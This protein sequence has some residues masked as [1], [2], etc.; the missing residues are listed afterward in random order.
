MKKKENES[1]LMLKLVSLLLALLIWFRISGTVKEKEQIQ[2]QTFTNILLEYQEVPKSIEPK[3]SITSFVVNVSGTEKDLKELERTGFHVDLSLG[4]LRQGNYTFPLTSEN[5]KFPLELTSLKFERIIPDTAVVNLIK[6]IRKE[7]AL[8]VYTEGEPAEDY[9]LKE[10]VLN[11]R[12]VEIEGPAREIEELRFLFGEN[13]NI[14]GL[15]ANKSGLITLETDQ[16]PEDTVIYGITNLR[17]TV[18]IE[19]NSQ[20]LNPKETYPVALEN[21]NWQINS[22]PEVKLEIEGPVTIIRW[23]DPTW[24]Q[25]TLSIPRPKPAPIDEGN[26]L[27]SGTQP[28]PNEGETPDTLTLPITAKY[29]VPQEVQ[30]ADPDW[31]AKI[32]RLTLKWT[33]AE[34]EVRNVKEGENR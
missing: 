27:Q 14:D 9:S 31:L 34:V 29:M 3:S 32:N 6:M 15:R 30:D 33:P 5:I 17:Y 10:I 8:E 25:A 20:T 22:Q 24:F 28:L 18:V 16:M 4:S 19:E 21:P 1:T 23:L 11:P 2:T 26:P 7:V 12:M 13:I